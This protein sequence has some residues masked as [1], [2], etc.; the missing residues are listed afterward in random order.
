M[1]RRSQVFRCVYECVTLPSNLYLLELTRIALC[2]VA[3]KILEATTYPFFAFIT[4]S[5]PRT[6]P[7]TIVS[8]SIQ[9]K[10]TVFSR[11]EGSPSTV[12]A[13]LAIVNHINGT[14]IPR[15]SSFMDR[16]RR[17]KGARDAERTMRAEQDRAY[18]EAANRDVQRIR[19]KERQL[20]QS[21]LEAEQRERLQRELKSKEENQARWRRWASENLVPSEPS[22]SAP[23]STTTRL[24]VKL[25][26]GRRLMRT[27]ARDNTLEQVYAW[28]DTSAFLAGPKDEAK[29]RPANYMHDY[30]FTLVN[31][32]PKR[33]IAIQEGSQ[34][35][36][37]DIEGLC[38]SASL[39]VEGMQLAKRNTDKGQ[40]SDDEES[41]EE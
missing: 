12:T 24:S 41:D 21:R 17:E 10:M 30:A 9:P 11:L 6:A 27:F 23:K 28:V 34:R 5:P 22:T 20:E 16:L 37:N 4:L 2:H 35:K 36:L 38:P 15:T 14:V 26:D 18:E 13:P 25:P 40:E 32:F 1:D 19:A 7:G 29:D 3:S 31:M 8:A 39:V 33:S